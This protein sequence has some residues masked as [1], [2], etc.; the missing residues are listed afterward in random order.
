MPF[1]M[2]CARCN[3]LVTNRVTRT[4]AGWALTFGIVEHRGRTSGRQY[5][6]LISVFPRS[7]RYAAALTYGPDAQR[8]R[9]VQAR[10]E[11][12]LETRGRR[13]HVHESAPGS[14]PTSTSGLTAVPH[15]P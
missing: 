11:A 3:R 2:A 1:P 14:R 6:T 4:F 15:H 8:V 13:H 9:N 7:D 5:R 10:G 12:G